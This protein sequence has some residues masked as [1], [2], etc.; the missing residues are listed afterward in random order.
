ML[1]NTVTLLESVEKIMKKIV[2]SFL[3]LFRIAENQKKTLQPEDVMQQINPQNSKL[4]LERIINTTHVPFL[5][6]DE[7]HR[8]IMLNDACCSFFEGTREQFIG[9]TD[10]DL[11]PKEQADICVSQDKL[12][13]STGKEFV[14]EE[15]LID[16]NG[17]E[18][19]VIIRKVSFTN[20]NS[21]KVLIATIQDITENKLAQI[22]IQNS[23]LFLEKIINA[24]PIP[25]FIKDEDHRFIMINDSFCSFFNY[26]R[27]E[28]L[29]KSDYDFFQKEEADIFWER[30]NQV[31]TTKIENI[32]EE[33]ITKTDG[34]EHT[35][36]TKKSALELGDSR[37]VLIGI[38]EDITKQKK[39]EDN[40]KKSKEYA[41][42][43]SKIKS[44]FLANMSHEIRTPMNGILGF[45]NLLAD[46][47]LNEEQKDFVTQVQKSSN[48]LLNIINDILD[49][50]KIEAGKMNLENSRFEIRTLAQDIINFAKSYSLDKHLEIS[51]N[52]NPDIPQE[53]FGDSYRLK[54]VL[55]NLLSNAIKFTKMGQISLNI[56]LEEDKGN[57]VILRFDVSDTG[58]GI[59]EDKLKSIFE[60]FT[61]AD[62]STT[63]QY[64]GTGLGL[65]IVKKIIQLMNGDITVKSEEG[66]G[67][68]FTFTAEFLK[69]GT[70][71]DNQNICNESSQF[72]I[73]N[74]E[75]ELN[76]QYR[77]LLAEDNPINQ[78]LAIKI[79]D[80]YGY[81]CDIAS[82]GAEAIETFK[83][84]AYDLILMDCQMPILDGYQATKEIRKIED[85]KS[86]IPIIAMTASVLKGDMDKCLQAGMDDYTSKPI[87]T[88]KLIETI[89]K[90]LT[91]NAS[92]TNQ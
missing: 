10:Y 74:D 71:D 45:I 53:I 91:V 1:N 19:N 37:L 86:H 4:F 44:E 47:D 57:S 49:I 25:I 28:M 83:T 65:S 84:E 62:V 15:V 13:L 11:F 66:K 42:Q 46:T 69:K 55:N 18:H 33:K 85:G 80:K 73:R 2:S 48:L 21:E 50:S 34:T 39:Y 3:G 5:I 56:Q 30:D 41:E 14:N 20:I 16:L 8:F 52:I 27:E 90:H 36:I 38:I 79:L 82:N 92:V 68:V 40:L 75:L 61:Q 81:I 22:K 31:L 88:Q 58:I 24:T 29:G 76:K 9:K 6:K 72:S 77:L 43:A 60:S 64:G 7:E 32:N 59:P 35:I 51:C 23:Q 17:K 87:N 67:S 26:S 70:D 54:Q 63:R 78:K 12:V 89:K